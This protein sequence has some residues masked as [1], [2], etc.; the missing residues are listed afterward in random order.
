[1]TVGSV[2]VKLH[3]PLT[4]TGELGA[5][6]ALEE[7]PSLTPG[8]DIGL[9]LVVRKPEP[10]AIPELRSVVGYGGRTLLETP[11]FPIP[12]P[13]AAVFR[14]VGTA[15]RRKSKLVDQDSGNN[16]GFISTF[17]YCPFAV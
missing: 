1:M 15:L 12:V 8:M 10:V 9:V 7:V 14:S 3:E 4:G 5:K 11:A 16:L 17:G 2:A 6:V 13:F